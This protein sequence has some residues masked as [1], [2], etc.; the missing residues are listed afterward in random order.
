MEPFIGQI[1]LVAFSYAPRYWALCDGATLAIATNQALFSILGTTYGGDGVRTFQLP[2]LRGRAAM[3]FGQNPQG[4]TGGQEQVFLSTQQIPSH[5]HVANAS[6]AAAT[7]SS[8]AN[9]VWAPST[10]NDLQYAPTADTTMAP[11]ALGGGGQGQGHDNMHPS[12]VLN[13]IIALAGI[14]PSR[15]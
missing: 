11:T 5:I 9:A 7:A 6:N 13:F 4:G 2:D 3:H 12:L 1:S 14:F 10:G 8:P 15:T